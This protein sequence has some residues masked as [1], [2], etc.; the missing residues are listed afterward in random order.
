MVL[1]I[2]LSTL[3]DQEMKRIFSQE[4]TGSNTTQ[5][6]RIFENNQE[7]KK[8]PFVVWRG[9]EGTEIKQRWMDGDLLNGGVVSKFVTPVMRL[10]SPPGTE[11]V[12]RAWLSLNGLGRP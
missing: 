5:K 3:S 10:L 12:D 9:K 2:A 7:N 8:D 4:H 11:Q 6:E 1:K